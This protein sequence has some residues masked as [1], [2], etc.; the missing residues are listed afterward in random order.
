MAMTR[1]SGKHLRTTYRNTT[2]VSTLLS[3]ISSVYRDLPHW[4]LNLQQQNAEPKLYHRVTNQHHTQVMPNQLVMVIARPINLKVSGKLPLYSLQRTVTSRATSSQEDWF[5]L[6]WRRSWYTL[7]MRPNKVETKSR[8]SVCRAQV[9]AGFPGYGNSICKVG[10]VLDFSGE[11]SR[12][13]EYILGFTILE[14]FFRGLMSSFS[15]LRVIPLSY[16]KW[17]W[18]LRRFQAWIINTLK[19]IKTVFEMHVSPIL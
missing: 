12:E 13:A 9:F 5:D 3:L 8:V 10:E 18:N 14:T 1:K 16:E 15:R 7:L 6:M 2:A 4:R 11:I 19:N 17:F